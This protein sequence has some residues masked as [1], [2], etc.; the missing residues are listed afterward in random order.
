MRKGCMFNLIRLAENSNA[1]PVVLDSNS[2]ESCLMCCTQVSTNARPHQQHCG[3][4]GCSKSSIHPPGTPEFFHLNHSVITLT[5]LFS[6]FAKVMLVIARLQ[7]QESSTLT[8]QQRSEQAQHTYLQFVLAS[9][10]IVMTLS[11]TTTQSHSM[12]VQ[13]KSRDAM[14]T[15]AI[16]Q[17]SCDSSIKSCYQANIL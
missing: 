6:Y 4:C 14:S 10:I 3:L 7:P 1:K 12:W 13:T 2:L 5:V 15:S 8:S 9:I 16:N 17:V 11:N